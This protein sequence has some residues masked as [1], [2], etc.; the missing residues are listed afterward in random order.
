MLEQVVDRHRQIVVRIHQPCRGDDTVTVVVWVIGKGQI[1]LVAQRQQPRHR[2]LGG[3]VHADCTIFVEM[4]KAESLINVIVNDSQVQVVVLSNTLPVFDTGTA[5]RIDTQRQTRF[6]DRRH[7]YDVSQSFNKRLNQILLFHMTRCQRSVQRHTLHALQTGRQ[8]RVG[9][10]FH[11]FGDIGVCRTTVWRVVFNAAIFRRVVGRR[12]HNAVSQ[13][14]AF[15]VV[16]QDSVRYSRG[17]RKAVIFL[18]D[19]VNAVRRQHFQYRDK[20]RFRQR[21]G[22]L[23]HIARTSNPVFRTFFSNRLGD[24]QNMRL[25]KTMTTC[26]A[27]MSGRTELNSVLSVPCRW[28]QYIVLCRQLGD[29]NQIT[30]LRRLTCTVVDCHCLVLLMQGLNC[31]AN[32]FNQFRREL[33]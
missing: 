8:Q 11:H 30:L 17:W 6:L 2:T 19:D 9:S 21:V 18:H 28:F 15:F 1:E 23:A 29:V 24:S 22:I 3:A 31:S 32:L 12:D 26:T 14:A 5:Q 4:H 20:S 13:R 33:H 16:D 10:V 7:V 27:A 25:V